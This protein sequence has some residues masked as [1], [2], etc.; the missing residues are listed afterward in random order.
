MRI[1]F[2]C[3]AVLFVS[4]CAAPERPELARSR[5]PTGPTP[6]GAEQHQALIGAEFETLMATEIL[7]PVR[8]IRPNSAVT[9][10]FIEARLNIALDENDRVIRLSCG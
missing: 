6:C 7:G 10:D 4:A 3:L 8:V 1:Y 2:A 9:M 5:A